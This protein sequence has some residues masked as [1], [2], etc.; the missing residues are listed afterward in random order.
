MHASKERPL[1]LTGFVSP[2][3][4]HHYMCMCGGAFRNDQDF[5]T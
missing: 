1:A 5:K 2:S 3:L 4:I